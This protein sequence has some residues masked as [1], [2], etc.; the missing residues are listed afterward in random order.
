MILKVKFKANYPS[1]GIKTMRLAE[2]IRQDTPDGTETH[3]VFEPNSF[4]GN[5]TLCEGFFLPE[6]NAKVL[7][8]EMQSLL[9]GMETIE[10][11]TSIKKLRPSTFEG[12]QSLTTLDIPEGTDSIPES[13]FKDCEAL[14]QLNM[15]DTVVEIGPS[16]FEN[17]ISLAG[18]KLPDGMGSVSYG[19]FKNCKISSRNQC[20]ELC[21]SNWFIR[22]F[23]LR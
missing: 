7:T 2:V 16:A 4:K 17:C 12:C 19:C 3:A 18:I 15:S 21:K 9:D 1:E 10:L 23:G 6:T 11:P 8:P 13:C 5:E 20:S 22:I 14:N